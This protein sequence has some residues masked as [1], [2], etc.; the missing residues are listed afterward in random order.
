MSI[1]DFIPTVEVYSSTPPPHV[2]PARA[3]AE[4]CIMS[5]PN[6]FPLRRRQLALCDRVFLFVVCF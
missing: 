3:S 2:S 6:V 5:W 4:P 1:T